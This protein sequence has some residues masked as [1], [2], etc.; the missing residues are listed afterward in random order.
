[1]KA[2]NRTGERNAL[3]LPP[4]DQKR[5]V[6]VDDINKAQYFVSDYATDNAAHP[7]EYNY[8]NQVYAVKVGDTNIAVVY[9]L[10]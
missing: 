10:R 5:I 7:Q 6:F 8:P 9:R 4:E 2:A 1:M 3:M